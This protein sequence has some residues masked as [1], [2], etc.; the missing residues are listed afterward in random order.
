MSK[1]KRARR[2]ALDDISEADKR[3][4]GISQKQGKADKH[5]GDLLASLKELE[6]QTIRAR[7][8]RLRELKRKGI[9]IH[10][11]KTELEEYV[12]DLEMGKGSNWSNH[13]FQEMP[14]DTDDERHEP[15]F[16]SRPAESMILERVMHDR[17]IMSRCSRAQ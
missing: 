5:F 1:V 6:Q 11:F 7:D 15:A 4:E 12:K 8:N 14:S 10:S 16:E 9:A 2:S 3:L 17:K 13:K